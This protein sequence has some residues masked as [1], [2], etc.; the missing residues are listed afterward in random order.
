MRPLVCEIG[1]QTSG[2][3]TYHRGSG[4]VVSQSRDSIRYVG[5]VFARDFSRL[6][7]RY[8][9]FLLVKEE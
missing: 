3:G 8:L 9:F 4:A 2:R 1:S 5:N 7:V 6:V